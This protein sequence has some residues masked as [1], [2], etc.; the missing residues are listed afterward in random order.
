MKHLYQDTSI[1]INDT[2]IS[3]T[4]AK[5]MQ[6]H[7]H[8]HTNAEYLT[9]KYTTGTLS[10]L[11]MSRLE[12]FHSRTLLHTLYTQDGRKLQSIGLHCSLLMAIMQATVI[13][14]SH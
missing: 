7:T 2:D 9:T 3:V 10:G 1:F 11:M 5:F 6:I 14:S 8:T 4:N 12:G 13:K